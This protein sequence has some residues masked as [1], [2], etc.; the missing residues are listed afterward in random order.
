[1]AA[2][3]STIALAGCLDGDAD[4][5]DNGDDGL[6]QAPYALDCTI[7]N[8]D[9]P[10]LAHAS[11]N[12]SPSKTEVDLVVNP[13]DP[14]NVVVASKDLDPL[15]SP[16]CVWAVA[17]VSKDGGRTWTTSY[18]GG[19]MAEREPGDLLYGYEC[20]TDPIMTFNKDGDLFYNLQAYR[21]E[22]DVENPCEPLGIIGCLPGP[23]QALMAMAVSHDGG[24]T[25]SDFVPE[26]AGEWVAIIPDYMHMGHNPAT[27]TVFATWNTITGLVTSNPTMV[28]YTG[29]E[30]AMQPT[31]FPT[32]GS[33]TGYGA[34]TIVGSTDG[35][36]Y[37]CICSFNSAGETWWSVSTDDGVTWSTPELK[38]TWEP[39]PG[40]LENVE[41]RTGTTVETAIDNSGG[42]DDGCIYAAW[43]GRDMTDDPGDVYV[44]KTCDGGTMWTDPV[45]VNPDTSEGAQLFVRTAV[46]GHGGVHIVY[47]SQ[48]YDLEH[49]HSWIDAEWAY[50][51]DGGATWTTQR[52][53]TISFDGDLG[54]HQDGGPFLGD[55]IG[56]GAVGDHVYMGF[57]TTF[58]GRAEIAVAHAY[59]TGG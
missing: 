54:I 39:T 41:F 55:Y 3:L 20:I 2:A 42:P 12:D 14:M 34:S 27:G 56:I 23:D 29:V 59:A 18:V 19:T 58:T 16:D 10:C 51:T 33:P 47:L 9:E 17:Q 38:W 43:N 28:R 46:D 30:P 32:P 5:D 48:H 44:R 52:L 35:T 22:V 1:M 15:A 45:H 37:F 25:W 7:S 11:P 57:P 31:L 26:F 24:L 49:D 40:N 36:L 50:S 6:P 21:Y 53:T 4:G 8:W 13:L